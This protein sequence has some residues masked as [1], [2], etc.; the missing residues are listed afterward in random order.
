MVKFVRRDLTLGT[1]LPTGYQEKCE[2]ILS[3]LGEML[4]GTET[5]WNYDQ[6]T[7]ANNFLSIPSKNGTYNW[8]VQYFVNESGSKL[9]VLVFGTYNTTSNSGDTS[10]KQPW[11]ATKNYL[12]PQ[13]R[14]NIKNTY[15]TD[16]NQMCESGIFMS[17]IPKG[18]SSEF[19]STITGSDTAV[20]IPSDAIPLVMD[21]Y[22]S[23]A[24]NINS[25]HQFSFLSFST[26]VNNILSLGL[27]VD[28]EMVMLFESLSFTASREPLVPVY[29]LGKIIGTLAHEDEDDSI[30]AHYGAIRFLDRVTK[31][32]STGKLELSLNASY[33]YFG[34]SLSFSKDS[35]SD[36]KTYAFF[37]NA[38]GNGLPIYCEYYADRV[39]LSQYLTDTSSS[40]EVRW[41][42]FA[43]GCLYD[44]TNP[45]Q[46]VVIGDG[47]KGYLDTNLFR[48]APS[49]FGSY[50][51]NGNFVS[52]GNNLLVAWDPDA[53]DTIM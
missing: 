46:S 18:S 7:P 29:A 31:N 45:L 3:T 4:V 42:P 21:G 2:K 35:D 19:P 38:E 44:V 47:F 27:L 41:T 25:W 53:T 8:P 43:L 13:N 52:L 5:G 37:Y 49:S 20:I 12:Y 48:Q 10:N 15:I 22:Y 26:T 6:R 9:M 40:T 39:L 32:S 33:S 36:A 14:E 30:Y 34:R 28:P 23:G 11:M 17:M 51:N 50:Y 1:E 16:Y 24:S